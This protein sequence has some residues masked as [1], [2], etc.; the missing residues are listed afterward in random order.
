M[1]VAPTKKHNEDGKRKYK[2]QQ[3]MKVICKKKPIKF[4]PVKDNLM[5]HKY[6]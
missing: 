4:M 6:K 3:K 2:W 1:K 5:K